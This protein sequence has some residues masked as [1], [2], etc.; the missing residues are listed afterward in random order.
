MIR[1]APLFPGRYGMT[2]PL[3]EGFS[4]DEIEPV[5]GRWFADP[6]RAG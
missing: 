6:A 3:S 4:R 2:E 5:A 1:A